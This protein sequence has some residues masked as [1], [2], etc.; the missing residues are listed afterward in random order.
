MSEPLICEGC[1]AVLK[2]G[3]AFCA[4]CG[5]ARVPV[6][7]R[8]PPLPPRSLFRA[9]WLYVGLLVVQ[10]VIMAYAR[11]SKDAFTAVLG[12][13][14]LF[15]VVTLGFYLPVRRQLASATGSFGL[16]WPWV[17]AIICGSVAIAAVV[18][19]YV[20]GLS[21]LFGIHA[22][23]ELAGLEAHPWPWSI[24]LIVILP[25]LVEE[26]AFRGVIYG[27]LRTSLSVSESLVVSAFAF[28]MIHMSIPTMLTHFPL[29]LYLGWLRHRSGSLWPGILAHACHNAIFVAIAWS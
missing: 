28:A 22:P 4:A 9:I 6:A 14:L 11:V 10:L 3:A 19:G 18:A 8:L 24:A 12:G 16:R 23:S 13:T 26:L 20:H 17:L 1:P 25:P 5:R 27:G 2:P 21:S 7:V 29:G 15:A